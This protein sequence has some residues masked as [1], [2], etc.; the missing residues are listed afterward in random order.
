MRREGGKN[1][2]DDKV[3]LS[4]VV[5]GWVRVVI[6]LSSPLSVLSAAGPLKRPH[7]RELECREMVRAKCYQFIIDK[8]EGNYSHKATV[9]TARGL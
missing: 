1:V 6:C 8:L 2:V 5:R 7:Y 3:F 9:M 4:A